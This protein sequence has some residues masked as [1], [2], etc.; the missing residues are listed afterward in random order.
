MQGFKISST[1]GY[2]LKKPNSKNPMIQGFHKK[3][4]QYKNYKT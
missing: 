3:I 2:K 4:Q 1:H